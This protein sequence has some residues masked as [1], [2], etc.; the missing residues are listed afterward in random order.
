MQLVIDP[1]SYANIAN[2]LIVDKLSLLISNHPH[3]YKLQQL[4]NSG[5][6][7]VIK[8]VFISFLIGYYEDE[9]LSDVMPMQTAHVTLGR[10]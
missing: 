7:R 1:G 4:N 2:S 9:I 8:Q 6:V 3:P 5:E 10:P